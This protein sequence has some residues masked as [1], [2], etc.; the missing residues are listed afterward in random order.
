MSSENL[1]SDHVAMR[2]DVS[3]AWR[4]GRLPHALLLTGEA[5]IGKR[6]LALWIACLR[7]CD[8]DDGPCGDCPSCKKV[9][10]GNHPDLE[11]VCRNPAPEL[12]PRGLG[13]RD[14][15][16]VAQIREG[17]IPAL[18]LKA[19]EDGGRSVVIQSAEDLNEQAQNALLKTLEEPPEGSLLVLVTARE[20]GLLDTIR[21]R[22][23]EIRLQPL[24]ADEMADREPGCDP[25]LLS[26]ARG[27]PGRLPAL[28]ALPVSSLI[29]SFDEVLARPG[30]GLAFGAS[31]GSM[32]EAA[33]EQSQEVDERT[34]R[35][36]VL[37]ILHARIR[38]LTLVKG[39][40]GA[41]S[42][43][44]GPPPE[45][46]EIPS[47]EVLRALET[48]VLEASADIRR[49]L[50]AAVAWA[51]LGHEFATALLGGGIATRRYT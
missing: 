32:V 9:L 43:L 39:G 26:L 17:V 42:L 36:L 33:G 47:I 46:Y 8:A 22:C 48:A 49:H 25:M 41:E 44:T 51:G 10:T 21:S 24:D 50:P 4:A 18:S 28:A 20:E 15:I 14:E 16:T 35:G 27:R 37:E 30:G 6:A 7:W 19:V 1:T 23:Q 2:R 11:V 38:D 40:H 34:L 13:S 45:G 3:A 31:L 29:A 12:D 5:G